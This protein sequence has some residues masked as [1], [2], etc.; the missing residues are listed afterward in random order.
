MGRRRQQ[1]VGWALIGHPDF[2]ISVTSFR[3]RRYL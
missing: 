2:L 1:Q 3:L